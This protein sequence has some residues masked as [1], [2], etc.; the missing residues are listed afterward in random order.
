MVHDIV[1]YLAREVIMKR[2]EML[3]IIRTELNKT[4]GNDAAK[5]VAEDILYKIEKAGMKPPKN[6]KLP[7]HPIFG[8]NEDLMKWELESDAV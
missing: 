3:K 2:S 7:I 5:S 4:M 6:Y 8:D 1:T